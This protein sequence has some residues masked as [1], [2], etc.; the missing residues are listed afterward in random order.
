[1]YDQPGPFATVLADVSLAS[2]NG[3]SAVEALAQSIGQDLDGFGA[4]PEVVDGVRGRLADPVHDPAPRSRYIVASAAGVLVD[5]VIP[6]A[7]TTPV[8][9]W[10][11]LPDPGPLLMHE[12]EARPFVLV[13][14]DHEGGDVRTVGGNTSEGRTQAAGESGPEVHKV[15]GGGLSHLQWQ[16]TAENLWRDNAREVASLAQSRVAE[17]H[18]LV[19]VAGS[20]ES[21]QEVVSILQEGPAKVVEL[22]RA[23]RASDGSTDAL[24]EDIEQVVRLHARER[25]DRFLEEVAERLGQRHA[26]AVGAAEVAD[27]LGQGAVAT[28]AIDP[29]AAGRGTLD[30]ADHPGLPVAPSPKARIRADLVLFAGASRTDAAVA[31]VDTQA[32]QGHD[33][34]GLLRWDP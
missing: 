22:D 29:A 21:R 27:S 8:V 13:R 19:I 17:G 32:L 7:V 30:P 25:V 14:V 3:A 1:M 26:V 4:P 24:C 11:P 33:A 6:V 15:R 2:E 23:G 20:V 12:A 10:E 5:E 28:V 9:E 34:V 31:V 18:R 16:R